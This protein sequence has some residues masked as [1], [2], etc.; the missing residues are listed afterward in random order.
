MLPFYATCPLIEGRCALLRSYGTI[1]DKGVQ[2][3]FLGL[4]SGKQWFQGIHCWVATNSLCF[5][6][7]RYCVLTLLEHLRR[8]FN[9]FH[10]LLVIAVCKHLKESSINTEYVSTS[11]RLSKLHPYESIQHSFCQPQNFLWKF[12]AD[13]SQLLD[14]YLCIQATRADPQQA[15]SEKSWDRLTKLLKHV[16]WLANVPY[17]LIRFSLYLNMYLLPKEESL[18]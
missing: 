11:I 5:P 6:M 7:S 13:H 9:S 18:R 8:W 3:Q 12:S 2:T 17:K 1:K 16:K 10:N 15:L 4:L 14:F